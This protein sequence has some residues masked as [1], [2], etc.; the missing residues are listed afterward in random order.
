MRPTTDELQPILD[1]LE[2]AF[3]V[4]CPP[5]ELS[6]SLREVFA[7]FSLLLLEQQEDR[8]YMV[9]HLHNLKLLADLLED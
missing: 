9:N 4:E 7:E 5:N 2:V 8:S 6:K 1:R 3:T